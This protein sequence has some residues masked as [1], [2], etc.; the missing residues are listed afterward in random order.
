MN[1]HR[2]RLLP[3]ALLLVV[4]SASAALGGETREVLA[5]PVDPFGV[6]GFIRLLHDADANEIIL[7]VTPQDLRSTAYDQ[8]FATWEVSAPQG[9]Q[10]Q[11]SPPAS[12]STFGPWSET[13]RQPVSGRYRA[14]LVLERPRPDGRLESSRRFSVAFVFNAEAVTAELDTQTAP[15]TMPR[16]GRAGSLAS[17]R[18]AGGLE[19]VRAKAEGAGFARPA[20]GARSAAGLFRPEERAVTITY[21][22]RGARPGTPLVATWYYLEGQERLQWLTQRDVLQAPEGEALFTFVI[23]DEEQWFTGDYVVELAAAG[24]TLREVFFA[25]RPAGRLGTSRSV[26]VTAMTVT[27]SGAAPQPAGPRVVVPSDAQRVELRV[28]YQGGTPGQRLSSRWYFVEGSLRRPFSE[29]TVE[30][31]R[32]DHE[33]AFSFALQPGEKWLPGGYE[34]DIYSGRELVATAAYRVSG[35]AERAAWPAAEPPRVAVRPDLVPAGDEFIVEGRGFTANGQIALEGIALTDASGRTERFRGTPFRLS[36][37]GTF[38]FRVRLPVTTAPGAASIT[39]TD[40][41]RRTASVSFQVA[42]PLTIKEQFKEI[43]RDWKGIFR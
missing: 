17:L 28:A 43:E 1:R 16:A 6:P 41:A 15:S 32:P 35:P 9:V 11:P 38:A 18:R 5:T 23:D 39:V 33:A 20:G 40:E 7:A 2:V 30:I 26:A 25:V 8:F 13:I 4:S 14:E 31:L 29:S 3:L 27:A 22:W 37:Q 21:T 42:R 10:T 24:Q 19:I 34:V 12:L 36:P